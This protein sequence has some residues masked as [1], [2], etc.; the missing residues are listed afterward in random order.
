MINSLSQKRHSYRMSLIKG[1]NTLPE[2]I[3]RRELHAKGFR[4]RIHLR[5]LPGKPDIVLP[6]HKVAIFVH[7]CFWHGH[8]CKKQ[9][10]PK[11]NTEFWKHKIELN[12]KRD[13]RNIRALQGRNWSVIIIWECNLEKRIH[14]LLEYL[15]KLDAG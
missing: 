5:A 1:K 3:V 6:R 7:G 4:F 10:L 15:S 8:Y 13:R 11:T 12:K 2:L 9:K 14:F